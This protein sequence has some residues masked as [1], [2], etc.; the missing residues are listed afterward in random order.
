MLSGISEKYLVGTSSVLSASSFYDFLKSDHH[1]K[2]VFICNGTA[3]MTSG[4]PKKLK[5]GIARQ[6]QRGGDWNRLLPGP[7]SFRQ[8]VHD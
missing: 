5:K 7:L 8:S 4:K 1:G 6:I 2:K 3:C